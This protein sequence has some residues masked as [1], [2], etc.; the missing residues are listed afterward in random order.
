MQ[1]IEL[2]NLLGERTILE[3]GGLIEEGS[4][5]KTGNVLKDLTRKRPLSFYFVVGFSKNQE[6]Q[7]RLWYTNSQFTV[8]NGNG[9]EIRIRPL[10]VTHT[11][12]SGHTPWNS[13]M[14]FLKVI[15]ENKK[16]YLSEKK[17]LR[18]LTEQTMR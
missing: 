16:E 11:G 1:K 12:W 10:F 8:S 14:P 9:P 18:I 2:L 7:K 6:G 5:F 3:Q 17:I 4:R 15:R 13:N